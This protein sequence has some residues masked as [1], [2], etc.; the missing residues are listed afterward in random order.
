M[1][2]V[3]LL[4]AS[5][6]IK[7]WETRM[8]VNHSL[9]SLASCITLYLLAAH[10]AACLML[11]P[12]A[13]HANPMETWLASHGYCISEHAN[14][15]ASFEGDGAEADGVTE[16]AAAACT[17]A[18]GLRARPE[19]AMELLLDGACNVRCSLPPDFYVVSVFL[20][21]QII[22]G[23]GGMPLDTENYSRT[24]Q[25]IFACVVVL[26]ALLWGY[27]VGTFVSV[28][29]NMSP[30]ITWFKLTLDN[31]NRF[32]S[33]YQLPQEMRVRLRE[34]FQMSRHIHRGQERN[35]LMSLMSPSLQGEVS[36]HISHRWIR[37]VRFL[38]GA[39][40]DFIILLATSLQPAVFAPGELATT[41][42]LYII[43][44]GVALY[45]G[46]VMTS[47]G[48][49]GHD[50][51]LRRQ[52]LCRYA[53]RAMSYL[54]VHRIS[55]NQ[56]LEL[57][58]PFPGAALKI[59]WEAIRLS[60]KRT[61][62]NAKELEMSR[63]KQHGEQSGEALPDDWGDTFKAASAVPEWAQEGA[64]G[65]RRQSHTRA[66]AQPRAQS[67]AR[68][69]CSQ[70]AARSRCAAD[71]ARRACDRHARA[72]HR[73]GH[74]RARDGGPG[75]PAAGRQR[76]REDARGHRQGHGR[77]RRHARRRALRPAA[78]HAARAV[79]TVTDSAESADVDANRP[80]RRQAA[81]GRS[82]AAARAPLRAGGA[83]SIRA[84][85]G[86]PP[87]RAGGR[88]R[89]RRARAQGVDHER[90]ARQAAGLTGERCRPWHGRRGRVRGA[91]RRGPRCPKAPTSHA[92]W[93][94][95]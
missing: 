29:S 54:E 13:F 46:R 63:R 30:D 38:R 5:R 4:R 82:S 53:A 25:C 8:A 64:D 6:I 90:R 34:Y 19:A 10:W 83:A 67:P 55:R 47:G 73:D 24:E 78:V 76:H 1:K 43:H 81:A 18:R 32:C 60:F 87:K 21:L 68:S 95:R 37:S 27:V 69:R 93:F 86:R 31:L 89:R 39:E 50:M 85:R 72:A 41:G 74:Q 15:T 33:I 57:A 36:M 94:V 26:G 58:R 2:L 48:V 70:C 51:I 66:L 52:E 35:K 42:Y 11:M 44:K 22:C 23:T 7:R 9:L 49:F 61:M 79:A 56:L 12:T 14:V 80:R 16:A 45:G 59:R 62:A 17:F 71:A 20:A 75:E 84:P 77:A 65:E 88:D 40:N 3:R 92:S 28:I 91:C